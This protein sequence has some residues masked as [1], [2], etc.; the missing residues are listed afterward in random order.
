[1]IK[2]RVKGFKRVRA[3][4]LLANPRNY[5]THPEA[6]R[7]ALARVL[8]TIGFAGALLARE[9]PDGSLLLIDGHLRADIDPEFKVPVL[10]T[11]LTPAEADQLLAVFDPL[12]GMAEVDTT[13]LQGLLHALESHQ[14]NGLIVALEGMESLYAGLELIYPTTPETEG[15]SLAG[16]TVEVPIPETAPQRCEPGSLWGIGPHRLIIGDGR[17]PGVWQALCQG[18]AATVVFTSPPYADRRKYDEE[19]GFVPIPP[20]EYVSW[21]DFL[22]INAYAQLAHDGSFFVNI[23]EHCE[24]GGRSLYVKD[25][26]LA[27]VREWGWRLVDEY[28]WE[29]VAMPGKWPERFKNEWEP[30]FHFARD[31]KIKFRPEHVLQAFKGDM[32]DAVTP[33]SGV[34]LDY[35]VNGGEAATVKSGTL[36][37]ALP[38]NVL[39]VSGTGSTGHEAAFPVG[40]PAFFI[41]AFSDPEDLV[42]DPFS[43]SGTTIIAAH[44]HGRKGYGIELSPAYGDLS[45]A[46]IEAATG[47]TAERLA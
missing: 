12:T 5:R 47:W 4:D 2:D 26:T 25:L 22:Q 30:V 24:D 44:Q 31:G 38:G 46:R 35:A 41:Q 3:G 36:D 39:S 17:S 42:I 43:G 21:W 29:R 6:Q 16:E 11:D 27:M 1:M 37:G 33:G 9:Q 14:K 18:E 32:T 23:K 34:H 45:L 19:A 7:T 15:P 20:E 8:E 40:L 10:V 28:C 13:A